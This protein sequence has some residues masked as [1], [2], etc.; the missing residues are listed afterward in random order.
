M[1]SIHKAQRVWRSNKAQAREQRGQVT[2]RG[3]GQRQWVGGERVGWKELKRAGWRA[4]GEEK[5]EQRE[6]WWMVGC[7]KSTRIENGYKYGW[8]DVYV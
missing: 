2:A 7:F 3:Y 8:K 4:G 5:N 6:S 1:Q